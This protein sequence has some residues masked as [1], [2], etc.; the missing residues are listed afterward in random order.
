MYGIEGVTDTVGEIINLRM[1]DAVDEA[2]NTLD[3]ADVRLVGEK[4][5]F[6]LAGSEQWQ[7]LVC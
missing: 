6:L 7:T 3:G 1:Y 4:I 2:A 5:Y